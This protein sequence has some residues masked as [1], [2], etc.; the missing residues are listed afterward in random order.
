MIIQKI[1]NYLGFHLIPIKQ[2]ENFINMEVK[3]KCVDKVLAAA[4]IYKHRSFTERCT[5]YIYHRTDGQKHQH[6]IAKFTDRELMLNP[7]TIKN[8]L[9]KFIFEGQNNF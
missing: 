8:V 5:Y 6:K 7:V 2:L 1:A 3:A 9:E 4:N